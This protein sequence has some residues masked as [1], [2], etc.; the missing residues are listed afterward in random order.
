MK[1][2]DW[3]LAGIE[4]VLWYCFIYYSLYSIKHEVNLFQSSFILLVLV[5]VAICCCP[6]VRHSHAWAKMWEK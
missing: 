6:L 1:Q 4:A 5:Y 3:I 2:N